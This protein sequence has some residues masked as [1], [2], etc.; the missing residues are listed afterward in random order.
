M[1]KL[2]E[3]RAKRKSVPAAK[4]PVKRASRAPKVAAKKGAAKPTLRQLN[5]WLTRNQEQVL[6]KA[7]ANTLRLI[8]RE[9]L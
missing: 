7:R 4:K 6:Q 2:L 8:G 1:G 5:A 3:T 9:T